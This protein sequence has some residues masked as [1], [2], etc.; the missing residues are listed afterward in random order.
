MP[1]QPNQE[2]VPL[3]VPVL[4][5]T[6]DGLSF[7]RIYLP[8]DLRVLPARETA[9]K[10]V[11]ECQKRFSNEIP[12]LDPIGHMKIEDEKFKVLVEVS[13]FSFTLDPMLNLGRHH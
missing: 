2:G 13:I 8:K 5:S 6:V 3:V 11:L 1:C 4:L 9:W 10:S 7:I 12:M